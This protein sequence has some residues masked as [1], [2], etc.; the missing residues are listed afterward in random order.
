MANI[1]TCY[2]LIGHDVELHAALDERQVDGRHVAHRQIVIPKSFLFFVP[3]RQER[4][5]DA[6]LQS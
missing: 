3:E 2:K 6:T 4:I 5:D 1:R